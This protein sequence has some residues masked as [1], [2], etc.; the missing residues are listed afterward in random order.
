MEISNP[1]PTLEALSCSVG[2][3]VGIRPWF[4]IYWFLEEGVG[5]AE[6][7]KAGGSFDPSNKSH[8][9]SQT[10]EESILSRKAVPC[11]TAAHSPG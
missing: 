4:M 10:S 8:R 7:G 2:E 5:N 6:W 9:L 3:S 1:P 11:V